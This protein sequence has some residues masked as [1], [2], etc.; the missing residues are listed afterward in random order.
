MADLKQELTE[1]HR[2][3]PDTYI[4]QLCLRASEEIRILE[5][6]VSDLRAFCGMARDHAKA[7]LGQIR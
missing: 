2:N 6:E 3:G 4:G 5:N 1:Q 7:V